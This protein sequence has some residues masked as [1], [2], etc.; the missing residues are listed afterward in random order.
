MH[1]SY[2]FNITMYVCTYVLLMLDPER[3]K[4]HE[5][6]SKSRSRSSTD[7]LTIM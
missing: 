5:N 7:Y 6:C 3:K 2:A 1:E 4:K